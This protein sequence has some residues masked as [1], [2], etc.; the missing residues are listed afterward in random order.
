MDGK[1]LATAG[2]QQRDCNFVTVLNPSNPGADTAK[3]LYCSAECED[4]AT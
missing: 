2:L 1:M 3:T 4:I